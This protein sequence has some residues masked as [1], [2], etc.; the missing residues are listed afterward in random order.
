LGHSKQS[1]LSGCSS[2]GRRNPGTN[3]GNA[4][5]HFCSGLPG[6][7]LLRQQSEVDG[8][9]LEAVVQRFRRAVYPLI[10]DAEAVN[11]IDGV[12]LHA[13]PAVAIF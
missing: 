11:V 1:Y 6:P 4:G 8:K 3:A 9:L 5:S 12:R 7:V 2:T 10:I 13:E